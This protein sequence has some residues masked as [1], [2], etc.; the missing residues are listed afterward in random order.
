MIIFY[1]TGCFNCYA[2]DTV[3]HVNGKTLQDLYMAT[4]EKTAYIQQHG[5]RLVSVWECQIH[6]ELAADEEM[7]GYLDKHEAA[8]P[9]ELRLA[10]EGGRG[11]AMK[12]YHACEE[13]KKVRYV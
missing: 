10:F 1:F 11:N 5:H 6:Q 13:G 12:L 8:T 3:N 7:T 9:L 2:R 4:V